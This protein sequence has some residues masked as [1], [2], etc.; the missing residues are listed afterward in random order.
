M[1]RVIAARRN[2]ARGKIALFGAFSAGALVMLVPAINYISGAAA[3]SGFV[4]YASL[5]VSDGA[6]IFRYWRELAMSLIES[7]PM[8]EF[9]VLAAIVLIF[10]YSARSLVHS[11][12]ILSSVS[13][14]GTNN[15]PLI[16][17]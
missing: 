12:S 14:F 10:V 4:E 7:A 13:T 11:L 17:Y 5:L 2:R 1:A 3:Q 15:A 8:V 16:E 6:N 9:A